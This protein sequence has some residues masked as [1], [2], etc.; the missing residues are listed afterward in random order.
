MT[1]WF[2]RR[3]RPACVFAFG[4]L[5]VAP[6]WYHAGIRLFTSS[7][8]ALGAA[9]APYFRATVS[10]RLVS[11]DIA[12]VALGVGFHVWR[13]WTVFASSGTPLDLESGERARDQSTR[14]AH[15]GRSSAAPR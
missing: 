12:F 8:T 7:W 2:T 15:R 4:R 13:K 10:I 11:A 14:A 6:R 5:F 3:H 9:E 1:P